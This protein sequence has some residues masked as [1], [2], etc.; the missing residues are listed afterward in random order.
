MPK[1]K[2]TAV[3][4]IFT[5]VIIITGWL[6]IS[7][8]TGNFFFTTS[9]FKTPLKAYNESMLTNQATGQIGYMN[10]S[11]D[12]GLFIGEIDNDTFVVADIGVKNGRYA[13]KSFTAFYQRDYK[14]DIKGYERI[15]TSSGTIKYIVAYVKSDLEK[16]KCDYKVNEYK[17]SSGQKI[18]LAVY[19]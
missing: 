11:D 15:K 9:Y 2:K 6:G 14:F 8:S 1:N 18:Y 3:I 16:L 13:H 7:I 19:K 10:L 4:L 12:T 17:T 5:A